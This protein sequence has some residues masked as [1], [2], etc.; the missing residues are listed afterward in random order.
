[1]QINN[2]LSTIFSCGKRCAKQSSPQSLHIMHTSNLVLFRRSL[3]TTAI[4]VSDSDQNWS[5]GGEDTLVGLGWC[6]LIIRE[7]W[8]L[9]GGLHELFGLLSNDLVVWLND[10]L[11]DVDGIS[12]G[13]V[14]TGHLTVHE[15]D[16][17]AKRVMSV[18]FVHVHDTSPGK[19]FKHDSVVL[20]GIGFSLEDFA[21]GDNLAL[22]LSNL[23]LSFHLIP[24][25]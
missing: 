20:D 1:M 2:D 22:A 4:A 14:S 24:E 12:S 17:S 13:A 9:A 8:E 15:G 16:G 21:D 25:L 18:F 5:G 23:V 11:D 10:G 6:S 3:N 19:I 7:F